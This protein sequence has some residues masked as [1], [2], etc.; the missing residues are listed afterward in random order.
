MLKR[1]RQSW[2]LEEPCLRP[3]LIVT[4]YDMS[5]QG[6]Y[7]LPAQG[8]DHWCEGAAVHCLH[9]ASAAR[10]GPARPTHVT[11]KAGSNA[12][13]APAQTPTETLTAAPSNATDRGTDTDTGGD[14][15]HMASPH[16]EKIGTPSDW[17]VLVGRGSVRVG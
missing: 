9:S 2:L 5:M 14:T 13:E 6:L 16:R 11:A 17:A 10:P 3:D 1:D 15:D 12:T 4:L 7:R 8:W